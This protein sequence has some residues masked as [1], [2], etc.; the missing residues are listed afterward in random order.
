MTLDPWTEVALFEHSNFAETNAVKISPG[1]RLLIFEH[2]NFTEVNVNQ[3]FNLPCFCGLTLT[4]ILSI[5]KAQW[6][7]SVRP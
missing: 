3:I 4:K 1:P 2:S 5:S 6:S 7:M